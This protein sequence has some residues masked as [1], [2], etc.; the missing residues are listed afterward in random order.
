MNND[1][2]Q[3]TTI[4]SLKSQNKNYIARSFRQSMFYEKSFRNNQNNINNHSNDRLSSDN[5]QKYKIHKQF[6]SNSYYPLKRGQL[7]K[8]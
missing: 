4:A 8:R 3:R 5:K 2:P 1:P 7:M 6:T